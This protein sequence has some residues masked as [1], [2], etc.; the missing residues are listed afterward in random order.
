MPER[1]KTVC[2]DNTISAV[3]TLPDRGVAEAS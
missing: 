1:P 2:E 3:R